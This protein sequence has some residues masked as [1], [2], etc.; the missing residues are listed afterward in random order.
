[1][2]E[3]SEKTPKPL[4]KRALIIGSAVAAG[5][6]ALAFVGI[7]KNKAH[8]NTTSQEPTMEAG[9]KQ[10]NNPDKILSPEET[11]ARIQEFITKIDSLYTGVQI[12]RPAEFPDTHVIRPN[13]PD[14]FPDDK[15]PP[16]FQTSIAEEDYLTADGVK[17]LAQNCNATASPIEVRGIN[18]TEDDY[19]FTRNVKANCAGVAFGLKL[20]AD[21]TGDPQAKTALAQWRQIHIGILDAYRI[22]EPQMPIQP[23][24]DIIDQQYYQSLQN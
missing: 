23:E 9:I 8:N 2:P 7:E 11:D 10:E 1:M 5:A 13:N 21:Q 17:K 3:N 15:I 14:K 4:P 20:L 19:Y 24:I 12:N 18:Y 22:T 16:Q 6:A